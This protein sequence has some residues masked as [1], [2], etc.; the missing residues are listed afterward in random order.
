VRELSHH[1]LDLLE[2]A[3]AAGATQVVL[4]ICEDSGQ[5][6]LSIEIQDNGRGMDAETQARALDPFF[7]TRTTRHVG[8]GL[9]LLKAAAERCNGG[10]TL[11]STPGRGTLVRAWFQREH[12]DRAPLGD[13]PSTLLGAL[14]SSRGDWDLVYAHRVDEGVF[15]LDTREMREVLGEDIPLSHPAIRQWL[16]EYLEQGY[17]ELYT[18]LWADRL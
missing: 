2:N 9:P 8:L 12:I 7:T 15:E 13:M 17:A 5:D 4:Q 16:E 14:L 3:L 1:V 10:L 6:M 11:A 18:G